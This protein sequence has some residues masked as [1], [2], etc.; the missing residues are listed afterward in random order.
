MCL[1]G[2]DYG[3]GDME[4]GQRAFDAV[5]NAISRAV[6]QPGCHVEVTTLVVPNGETPETLERAARWL[7]SVDP[8]IPYHVTQ[9]HPAYR[10][11]NVP[12]LPNRKVRSV[13]AT[14]QRHLANVFTGNMW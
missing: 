14:A 12:A 7:A 1:G 13:A 11:S 10:W 9:Y 8:Q 6:A 5:C 2:G 4:L 3:E